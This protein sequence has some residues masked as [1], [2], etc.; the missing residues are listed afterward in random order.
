MNWLIFGCTA[1]V[2]IIACAGIFALAWSVDRSF[3]GKR[4]E[5]D[6]R[7]KY[8]TVDNFA[9]LQAEPVEFASGNNTLR[10]F[11]YRSADAPR[12]L[13]IFV[14]G[15]GAGHLA[16]TT[17]ICTLARA[18]FCVLAYDATGCGKSD[19]KDMRGF[20]QGPRDLLAA[21]RFARSEARFAEMP[22]FFVGHSWGAFTVLNALPQCKGMACGAVAMC[23]FISCADSLARSMAMRYKIL[24]PLRLLVACCLYLIQA[25]RFRKYANHNSLRAL[26]LTDIPVLLLY[27]ERDAVIPYPANGA[28]IAKR[29][30]QK[31]SVSFQSF[32]AKGHNVYLTERAERLMHE[33]IA[34]AGSKAHADPAHAAD[35]YAA[36][37]WKAITEE[38]AAV[39]DQIVRFLY[40]CAGKGE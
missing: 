26:A 20:D 1:A 4:Y 23:G 15:F 37:D 6:P 36:I 19:G 24:S 18:G 33:Q 7:F 40:S 17:E 8:F 5:G 9:G 13:V 30:A 22:V 29:F 12:A 14:H 25:A 21:L 10:G 38:D 11:I 27:G 2:L 16:Y 28:V 32:P 34:A 39:M 3:F 31:N 35:Y